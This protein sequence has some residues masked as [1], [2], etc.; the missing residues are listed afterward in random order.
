MFRLLLLALSLLLA[1]CPLNKE[2]KN[3]NHN[4]KNNSTQQSEEVGEGRDVYFVGIDVSGSFTRRSYYEDS[5]KFLSHYLYGHVNGIG[6]M[7]K[8]HSLFVSEIGGLKA[9]ERKTFFP[10]ETFSHISISAINSKLHSL[11][12]KNRNNPYTDFNA[13][14][15]Q[16]VLTVQN[17]K[18]SM[19]P[20]TVVLITDG[21]PDFPKVNGRNDFRRIEFGPLENLARDVTVRVLY[22]TADVGIDWQTSIPRKKVKVWTQDAKVMRNWNASNVYF[23][24]KPFEKQTRFFDWVKNNVDFKVAKKRVN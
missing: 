16:I 4:N 12:P 20:I 15:R 10:I 24:K 21:V 2:D 13:F 7:A 22:T 9:D 1:G 6:G 18:L 23:K 8:L 3:K 19:R 17:K 5:I 11:F 14:F